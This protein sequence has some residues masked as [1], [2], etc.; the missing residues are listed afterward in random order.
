MPDEKRPETPGPEGRSPGSA[1]GAKDPLTDK[2]FLSKLSEEDRA[3]VR[4]FLAISLSSKAP[5]APKKEAALGKLVIFGIITLVIF[6]GMFLYARYTFRQG[7]ARRSVPPV[8]VPTS[9]PPVRPSGPLAA[10]PPGA[11]DGPLP[12]PED[13]LPPTASPSPPPPSRLPRR[14]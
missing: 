9:P 6:L 14:P 3:D 5:S 4:R 8:S 10:T 12:V 13:F 7:G 2:E 11:L 1:G